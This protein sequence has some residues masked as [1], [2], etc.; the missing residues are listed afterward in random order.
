MNVTKTVIQWADRELFGKLLVV[1]RKRNLDL[2]E[3]FKYE[4]S[5]VPLSI[6]HFNGEMQKTNKSKLEELEIVTDSPS[7]IDVNPS[8]TCFIIDTMA[9]IQKASSSKA[10]TFQELAE[11][12]V[13]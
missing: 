4:L 12:L 1:A 3:V 13:L 2:K 9:M 6:C 10:E 5:P 11:T 7:N 8:E